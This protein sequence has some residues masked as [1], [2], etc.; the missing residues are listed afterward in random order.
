VTCH[1]S[2][3]TAEHAGPPPLSVCIECHESPLTES[4]EE[5]KIR[6]YAAEGTE[7]PWIRLTQLADH[8]YFSHRRH[9]KVAG[10]EC[11]V[12]HGPMEMRTSPPTGPLKSISMSTCMECHEKTGASLD[13]NACHR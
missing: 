11:S 3:E 4:P 5:E 1:R 9:V 6:E 10:V 2:V 12:C 13:C 7:I 8:V